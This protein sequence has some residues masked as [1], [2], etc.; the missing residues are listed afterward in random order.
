MITPKKN[1]IHSSLYYFLSHLLTTHT[2]YWYPHKMVLFI[3]IM[4]NLFAEVCGFDA[5]KRPCF[6]FDQCM[7]C[8]VSSAANWLR[9]M[10]SVLRCKFFQCPTVQIVAIWIYIRLEDKKLLFCAGPSIL[11]DLDLQR[12][13]QHDESWHDPCNFKHLGFHCYWSQFWCRT[14]GID[15]CNAETKTTSC[16]Q[17]STP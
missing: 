1:F 14:F 8:P 15:T 4:Q 12:S 5:D 17:M 6:L 11:E 13:V 3:H 7:A 9:K 10:L 2:P 16:V